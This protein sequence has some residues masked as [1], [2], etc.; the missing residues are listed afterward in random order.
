[1][2]EI[3]G[4]GLFLIVSVLMSGVAFAECVDSDGGRNYFVKGTVTGPDAY[5]G[6]PLEIA[7]YVD[8]CDNTSIS[9]LLEFSCFEGEVTM[10]NHPCRNGCIDGACGLE[11]GAEDG[12]VEEEIGEGVVE[13]GVVIGSG[14]D[15]ECYGCFVDGKCVSQGYRKLYEF[16]GLEGEMAE[17]KGVGEEC[18]GS[19]ECGSGLCDRV[20]VEQSL[21]VLIFDWFSRFFR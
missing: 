16:C 14:S 5:G 4:V 11:N 7:T 17:L 15:V 2:R 9:K 6:A 8:V 20:C 19:F 18:G 12:E 3:R 10:T 1:M 13:D 21:F